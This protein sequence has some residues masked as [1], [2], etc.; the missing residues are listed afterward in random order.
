MRNHAQSESI[1]KNNTNTRN[2]LYLENSINSSNVLTSN[3]FYKKKEY[4]EENSSNEKM[5][6]KI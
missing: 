5:K 3:Q 4:R 6:K 1:S 2:T